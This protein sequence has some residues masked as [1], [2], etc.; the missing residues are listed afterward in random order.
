MHYVVFVWR[1]TFPFGEHNKQ[2]LSW[3]F[4]MCLQLL[5]VL[6]GAVVARQEIMKES[7]RWRN[8][9]HKKLLILHRV[10]IHLSLCANFFVQVREPGPS[11]SP[12]SGCLLSSPR[13]WTVQQGFHFFSSSTIAP[14]HFLGWDDRPFQCHRVGSLHH[15]CLPEAK[16]GGFR[17]Q[18]L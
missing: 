18:K 7:A 14:S 2:G 12:W 3:G 4:S 9:E 13:P 5:L 16:R 10:W 8:A 15:R 1:L 6:L 11:L 17:Q